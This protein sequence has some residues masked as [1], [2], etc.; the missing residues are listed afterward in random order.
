SVGI[1]QTLIC[2]IPN[3]RLVYTYR[4]FGIYLPDFKR[5][6][7]KIKRRLVKLKWRLDKLFY[8]LAGRK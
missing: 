8:H 1:Y 2:Y 5:H 7:S 6:F 3:F 4:I